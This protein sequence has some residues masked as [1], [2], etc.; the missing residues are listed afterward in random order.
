MVKL[1]IGCRCGGYWAHF[2]DDAFIWW[3][4]VAKSAG[5]FAWFGCIG[6]VSVRVLRVIELLLS[7]WFRWLV[8]HGGEEVV[9]WRGKCEVGYYNSWRPSGALWFS[10]RFCEIDAC[11]GWRCS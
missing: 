7:I 11:H 1:G 5:G 10:L 2:M 6:R 9:L 4:V 8:I 3:L